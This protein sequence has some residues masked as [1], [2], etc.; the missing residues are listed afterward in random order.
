ML[1]LDLN[2]TKEQ[3]T[4]RLGKI[5]DKFT[6]Y[7]GF[8]TS[9][10]I[11]EAL[12]LNQVIGD[13]S[14]TGDPGSANGEQINRA[15]S[16][17][18]A[19]S[20]IDRR[21]IPIFELFLDAGNGARKTFP[22]GRGD[23]QS[24]IEKLANTLQLSR[25][26]SANSEEYKKYVEIHYSPDACTSGA[27]AIFHQDLDT[28]GFNNQDQLER[29]AKKKLSAFRMQHPLLAQGQKNADLLT[30]FFNAFPA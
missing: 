7:F 9:G 5:R 27:G 18:G 1:K 26:Q 6:T 2:L 8:V 13:T 12:A 11:A 28:I 23:G 20:R 19:E 21:A 29:D 17:A 24:I 30:I 16:R 22:I 25:G 3:Q 14:P 15:R 4:V 10:S